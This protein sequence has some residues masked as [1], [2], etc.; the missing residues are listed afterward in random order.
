M[1][2]HVF[3]TTDGSALG[4]AALPLA[5]RLAATCGATL[6]VAFAVPDPVGVYEGPYLIDPGLAHEEQLGAVRGVLHEAALTLGVGTRTCLVDA[7]GEDIATALLRAAHDEQA[8]LIVMSTHG[9]GGLK[10]LLL[11]SVAE[12]VLRHSAIPVLLQRDPLTL[13]RPA[14]ARQPPV[15]V[16]QS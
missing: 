10:H 13:S 1:F 4:H 16:P 7:R 12:R 14:P 2:K 8:D 9:R 5:A 15:H 11:G 6:T 3:V